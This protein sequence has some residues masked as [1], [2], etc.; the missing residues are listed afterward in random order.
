L[1]EEWKE[2]II[3]P[4]YKKGDKTDCSSYRGKV[5]LSTTQRNLSKILQD[6]SIV[7][8]KLFRILHNYK[9]MAK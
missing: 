9:C 6:Y 2:S 3:V 1:P 4:I 7:P 8:R 5:L